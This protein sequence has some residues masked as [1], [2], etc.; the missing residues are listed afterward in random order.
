MKVSANPYNAR[1]LWIP[2]LY[3]CSV[4]GNTNEIIYWITKEWWKRKWM[5][6]KRVLSN[7]SRGSYELFKHPWAFICGKMNWKKLGQVNLTYPCFFQTGTGLG[8]VLSSLVTNDLELGKREYSG[9]NGAP[10]PKSYFQGPGPNPRNQWIGYL[11]K[12]RVFADVI[13]L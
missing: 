7:I 11:E 12:R 10:P 1:V 3:L 9:L 8:R 6:N 5:H 2:C 4:T 13:K